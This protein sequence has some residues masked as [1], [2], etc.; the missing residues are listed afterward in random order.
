[1]LHWGSLNW[2]ITRRPFFLNH[3]MP[4]SAQELWAWVK[5]EFRLGSTVQLYW[6]QTLRPMGTLKRAP[7]S[8]SVYEGLLVLLSLF[9]LFLD[10]PVRMTVLC[11]V[12]RDCNVHLVR[13]NRTWKWLETKARITGLRSTMEKMQKKT[14]QS[15][16]L[17]LP[18]N[19]EPE[20]LIKIT[21]VEA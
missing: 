10:L 13:R 19:S 8:V 15:R 7:V 11:M 20:M 4:W 12:A 17:K 16:L 9:G 3:N 6:A 5:Q 1:M 2:W 14:V 18:P 21:Q